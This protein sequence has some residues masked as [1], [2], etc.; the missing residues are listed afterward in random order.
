MLISD[1]HGS[2]FVEKGTGKMAPQDSQYCNSLPA[3]SMQLPHQTPAAQSERKWYAVFTLSQNEQSAARHLD[4]CQIESFVPTYESIRVWK[5]RQRKKVVQAM[6]PTYM[7][8]R[9]GAA[10]QSVVLRSPGV[11]RIIGNHKGPIPLPDA[12][13]DFLRSGFCRQRVEPYCDLVVG[14]KV[15]IKYGSMQGLE[16]VLVRK[17]NSLRF[18]LTLELINQ[19]AAVEVGADELEPVPA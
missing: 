6:F 10:E 13:I 7:F 4:A 16:G 1:G 9:I 18:V 3:H 19:S 14:E 8:V 2:R 12:E 11:R 15:R 17:K 5:N